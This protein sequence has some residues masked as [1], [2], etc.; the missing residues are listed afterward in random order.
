VERKVAS[1]EE[2]VKM[3]VDEE[4]TSA[5]EA[6]NLDN[7]VWHSD[8]VQNEVVVVAVAAGVLTRGSKAFPQHSEDVTITLVNIERID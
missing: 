1:V 3:A 6:C 7:T 2:D 5:D 8:L 4:L